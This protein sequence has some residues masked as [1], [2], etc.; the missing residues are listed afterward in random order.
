MYSVVINKNLMGIYKAFID[1]LESRVVGISARQVIR[2]G[3]V[4]RCQR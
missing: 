3:V 2:F 1:K 4:V